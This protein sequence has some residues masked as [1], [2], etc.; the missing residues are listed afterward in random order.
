MTKV[1][2]DAG[3][4]RELVLTNDKANSYGLRIDGT[5]VAM[6]WSRPL[7]ERLLGDDA[8]CQAAVSALEEA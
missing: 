5:V 2:K 1:L 7:M 8:F 4:G 6:S 3:S